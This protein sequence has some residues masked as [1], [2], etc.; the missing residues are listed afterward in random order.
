MATKNF[1]AQVTEIARKTQ[2]RILAVQRM[3][4][5]TAIDEMQTPVAK[6]GNMRVDTGFLRASGAMSLTGM[7]TGPSRND[8]SEPNSVPY[9]EDTPALTL[10]KVQLGDRV[11]WGW[12]ANYARYREYRD[13]FM[14]TVLQRWQRIVDGTVIKALE[15]WK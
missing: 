8:A 9:N 14:R 1:E 12:T 15:R 5:Q 10:A 2:A 4:I 7:P 3:S 11:Y 6:G 13:G